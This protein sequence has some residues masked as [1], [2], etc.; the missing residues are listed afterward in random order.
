VKDY[1]P[2]F[3][4][5]TKVKVK[6]FLKC[7]ELRMIVECGGCPEEYLGLKCH[8]PIIVFSLGGSVVGDDVGLV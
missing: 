8:S 1:L 4:L 6:T 3:L 7:Q 5:S 2:Q